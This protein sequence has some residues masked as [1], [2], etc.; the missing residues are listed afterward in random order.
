MQNNLSELWS[1][2]NFVLP[3]VFP[4]C[5]A[6]EELFDFSED[7]RILESQAKSQVL[8]KLH[9]ILSPFVLR[10]LKSGSHPPTPS[11]LLSLGGF[12]D[13]VPAPSAPADVLQHLPSKREVVLFSVLSPLQV[14][15]SQAILEGRIHEW[16]ERKRSVDPEEG[17]SSSRAASGGLQM[18]LIQLRKC[19][20]HPVSDFPLPAPSSFSLS[21]AKLM[22]FSSLCLPLLAGGSAVYLWGLCPEPGL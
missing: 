5:A 4:D 15:M 12:L 3:E 19:H 20:N 7:A 10:R 16:L 11:R 13:T 6:F 8:T 17:R 1:L 14:E 9:R 2:L 22:I 18:K 21:S